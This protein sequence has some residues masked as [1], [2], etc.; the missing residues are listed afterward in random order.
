MK[1]DGA[2]KVRMRV[3]ES[4]NEPKETAGTKGDGCEQTK[5]EK[6]DKEKK[7]ERRNGLTKEKEQKG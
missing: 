4:R 5:R 7:K 1:A 6:R 2:Q 3:A